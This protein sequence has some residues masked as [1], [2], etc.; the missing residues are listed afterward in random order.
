[1]WGGWAHGKGVEQEG[2]GGGCDA[3]EGGVVGAELYVEDCGGDGDCGDWGSGWGG[4]SLVVC[5]V[6]DDCVENKFGQWCYEDVGSVV[7]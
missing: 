5:G 2:A 7:A 6:V 1:M 3:E 4:V